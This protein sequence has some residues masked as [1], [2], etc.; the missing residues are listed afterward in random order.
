MGWFVL[1]QNL[2]DTWD[3]NYFYQLTRTSIPSQTHTHTHNRDAGG[4]REREKE[5]DTERE[6]RMFA[7]EPGLGTTL[8]SPYHVNDSPADF[9]SLLLTINTALGN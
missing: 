7:I 6:S 2:T 9:T 5:T 8:C 3:K 4:E 1:L